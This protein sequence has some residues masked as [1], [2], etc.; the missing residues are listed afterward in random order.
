MRE[1]QAVIRRTAKIILINVMV[2]CGL[3]LSLEFSY[4]VWM[5]FR[6]CDADCHS[7]ARFTRL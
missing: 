3:V 1:L 6:Y 4:R 5:Y 2:L 7:T